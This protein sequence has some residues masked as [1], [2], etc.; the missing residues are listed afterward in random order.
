MSAAGID[1]MT[2][3]KTVL[4]EVMGAYKNEMTSLE[5]ALWMRMIE[6]FGDEAIVRFLIRH[7]ETSSFAPKVNEAIAMLQPGRA[8]SVA[9]FEELARGV[10][11]FGPYVTP[12]FEDPA[13]AGAVLLLGGWVLVNEQLPDPKSRFDYDAF[14]KRFDAVYHQSCADLMLGRTCGNQALLGLH[15]QA[16]TQTALL[17]A[18]KRE[19][20]HDRQ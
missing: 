2:D 8:S 20:T 9:A 17:Q 3:A 19:V 18:P 11:R 10:K 12:E 13:I 1:G 15:A 6:D 14:F 7:I 5:A 4:A 16:S